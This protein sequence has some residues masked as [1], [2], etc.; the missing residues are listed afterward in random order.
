MVRLVSKG[1]PVRLTGAIAIYS[2]NGNFSLAYFCAV[3][4]LI[5]TAECLD[6]LKG[7][8]ELDRVD[9]NCIFIYRAMDYNRSCYEIQE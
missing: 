4:N 1:T 9:F 2:M 5:Q 3:S 7:L 6:A 8:L